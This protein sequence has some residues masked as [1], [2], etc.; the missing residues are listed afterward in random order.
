WT[1]GPSLNAVNRLEVIA[2]RSD[3]TPLQAAPLTLTSNSIENGAI[4]FTGTWV[5]VAHSEINCVDQEDESTLA[6]NIN[7]IICRSEC[8]SSLVCNNG[9][10]RT[11]FKFDESSVRI[12]NELYDYEGNFIKADSSAAYNYTF[13]GPNSFVLSSQTDPND[14]F[15]VNFIYNDDELDLTSTEANRPYRCEEEILLRRL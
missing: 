4:S 2:K 8:A 12:H 6:A 11:L 13:N 5:I 14:V 9:C 15:N 3:G 1:L 10:A 7:G